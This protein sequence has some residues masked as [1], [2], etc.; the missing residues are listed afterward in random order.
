MVEAVMENFH[1]TGRGRAGPGFEFNGSG[2]AEIADI[3]HV[4][5]AAQ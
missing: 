3:D 4:G 1:G 2:E 5:L